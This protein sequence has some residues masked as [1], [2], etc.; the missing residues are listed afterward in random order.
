[1]LASRGPV[2]KTSESAGLRVDRFHDHDFCTIV[3]VFTSKNWEGKE[4]QIAFE[5]TYNE[6]VRE[7]GPSWRRRAQSNGQVLPGEAKERK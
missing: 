4:Q 5:R 2:Y 1:M 7:T 3:P 6:V